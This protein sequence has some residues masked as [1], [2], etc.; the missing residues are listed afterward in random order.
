[1]GK[2]LEC[3]VIRDLFWG[4]G[5]LRDCVP[6]GQNAGFEESK[7]E[8]WSGVVQLTDCTKRRR[9]SRVPVPENSLAIPMAPAAGSGVVREVAA[10]LATRPSVVLKIADALENALTA[11][12]RTWDS[13]AKQWVEEPDTR[14]QLQAVFGLFAHFVG[15]PQKRVIHEHLAKDGTPDVL[16]ALRESPA[17]AAAMERA[18]EKARWR[19]SGRNSKTVAPTLEVE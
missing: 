13:G 7:T 2:A 10:E 3:P 11:T 17:L 18:L 1:M 12:R 6:M 19:Q 14:C 4:G 9:V 8:L 15:D 5:F 16:A